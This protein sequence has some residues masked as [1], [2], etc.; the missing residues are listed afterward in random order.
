VKVYLVEYFQGDEPEIM[1]V[2]ASK[3]LAET[4]IDIR[5]DDI[6]FWKSVE[7]KLSK[8]LLMRQYF[9]ITEMDLV[10]STD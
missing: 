2:Y 1:G 3:E 9:S 10:E 7:E 8:K 6:L 5:M 4:N